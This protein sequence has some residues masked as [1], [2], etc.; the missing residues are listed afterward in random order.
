[1]VINYVSKSW[2]DP[3]RNPCCSQA[4]QAF[5]MII[6]YELG[7]H[8]TKYNRPVFFQPP[9]LDSATGRFGGGRA[10]M[11]AH[12]RLGDGD[13]TPGSTNIAGWKMGAPD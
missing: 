4:F 5:G 12:A 3:P 11:A 2:D 10:E 13:G 1:M 8:P 9:G 6:N 7:A